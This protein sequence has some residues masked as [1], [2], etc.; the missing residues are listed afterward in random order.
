MGITTNKGRG[1]LE[2]QVWC[3]CVYGNKEEGASQ[4]RKTARYV[5]EGAGANWWSHAQAN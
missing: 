5:L 4:A 1:R 3:R 2:V